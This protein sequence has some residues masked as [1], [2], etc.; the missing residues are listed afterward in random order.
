MDDG[1][2]GAG[3]R[4]LLQVDDFGFGP[5]RARARRHQRERSARD[6]ERQEQ[7]H[8]RFDQGEPVIERA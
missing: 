3:T 8:G 5:P 7:G 1:R 4:A 6:D 2:S